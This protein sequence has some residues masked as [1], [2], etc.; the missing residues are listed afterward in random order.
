M[1]VPIIHFLGIGRKSADFFSI[2]SIV[3]VCSM[4][5]QNVS[6]RKRD[7]DPGGVLTETNYDD[8]GLQKAIKLLQVTDYLCPIIFHMC[9]E[10]T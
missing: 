4:A 7:T 5:A 10:I 3:L 6:M 8:M 1:M 9:N 2:F